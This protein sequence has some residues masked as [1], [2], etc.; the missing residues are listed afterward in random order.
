MGRHERA[1]RALAAL[2]RRGI[3][4]LG[5]AMVVA[6]GIWAA[7]AMA[8][9][10]IEIST[11]SGDRS[12]NVAEIQQDVHREYN[13]D[14]R[15][16][17]ID[18]TSLQ[19]LLSSE[20]IGPG[21][22]IRIYFDGGVVSNGEKFLKNREP[23]FYFDK[24]DEDR[25]DVLFLIPKKEGQDAQPFED[26]FNFNLRGA[27]A[28]DPGEVDPEQGDTQVFDATVIE[29]GPQNNYDFS[30]KASTGETGSDK[31]FELTF[32]TSGDVEISVFARRAGDVVAEQTIATKVKAPPEDND[33]FG[34][35]TSGSGF[36]TPYTPPPT[37][38]SNFPDSTGSGSSVPDMPAP[39]DPD[40][41][42]EIDEETGVS[43][44]GELLSATTPLPPAS[45]EE[46][47]K[48]ED[49]APPEPQEVADEA[50]EVSAPGALIAGGIVVGL[51]GLGA[52]R[53]VE[54]RRPRHL[55]KRL[56][57]SALRR[58]S[59]PWK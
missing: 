5:L 6:G 21:E 1:D 29:G 54:N 51:L 17:R 59:P 2:K 18:G 14:G 25:E 35:G 20:G 33:G 9:N 15:Q 40:E 11:P 7:V 47:S 31:K 10:E 43:V 27:I 19:R 23:V 37:F 13:I 26:A 55:F 57:F 44:T 50:K 28:I 16:V 48:P 42:P 36:S 49:E 41:E 8:A 58:L 34:S 53:E 24:E 52:G 30:W 46:G 32:S 45:G 38:E 12:V 4:L 3:A 39:P 22:W 56:D